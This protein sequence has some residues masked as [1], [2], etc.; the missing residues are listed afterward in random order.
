M[1]GLAKDDLA[2]GNVVGSNLY[3]MTL[4]LGTTAMISPIS[5]QFDR[6]AVDFFFFVVVVLMLV[7]MTRFGWRLSRVDGMILLSVYALSNLFIFL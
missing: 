4:I 2:I 6:N 1:R 3:N 5:Y 7:P